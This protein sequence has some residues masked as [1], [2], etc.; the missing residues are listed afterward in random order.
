MTQTSN[1]PRAILK[2]KVDA[3]KSP[4]ETK[5][6]PTPQARNQSKFKAGARW[7]SSSN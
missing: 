4:R 5:S 7:D 2:L 6:P 1:S 3:R